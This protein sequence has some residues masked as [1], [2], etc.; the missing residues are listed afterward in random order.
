[1]IKFLK[2]LWSKLFGP[3]EVEHSLNGWI[4]DEKDPRDYKY[5]EVAK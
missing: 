4:P 3:K 5:D 2:A 1:M